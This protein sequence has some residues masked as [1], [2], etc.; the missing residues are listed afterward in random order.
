[1]N[2]LQYKDQQDIFTNA[3]LDQLQQAV[4]NGLYQKDDDV[5]QIVDQAVDKI[6]QEQNWAIER[7]KTFQK[8]N[9][10]GMTGKV[11]KLKK[12][13]SA[14]VDT[15]REKIE[16]Y[17]SNI[18]NI[19][20]SFIGQSKTNGISIYYKVKHKGKEVKARFSDHGV[21]NKD[22]LTDEAHFKLSNFEERTPM[23][24]YKLGHKDYN[25]GPTKTRK[26]IFE[27]PIKNVK[28]S[29]KEISRRK[30]KKGNILVKVERDEK[31]YYDFY[32]KKSDNKTKTGMTG[33]ETVDLSDEINKYTD[34]AKQFAEKINVVAEDV[35]KVNDQ[36]NET[37]QKVTQLSTPKR[38]DSRI[39]KL[40][41][42]SNEPIDFYNVAGETGKFLQLVER[43]S[44]ESV[45][46]TLDGPQGAGKTTTMWKMMN[47]FASGGNEVLFFSLEEH[48]DSYLVEDKK[49]QYIN[50]ANL[51]LINM[52]GDVNDQTDFYS[53][54]KQFDII[55]IDSWQKLIEMVGKIKFDKDMRKHFDGK[56]FVVI[57]QQTVQGK[58][59]GG[60]DISFDGDIIIKLHKDESGDFSKNYAYYDKH[61]YTKKDIN[62][63]KYMIA[64][65]Q[66]VEGPQQQPAQPEAPAGHVADDNIVM[67]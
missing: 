34:K 42:K 61:R 10:K 26:K 57:F 7:A 49:N 3:E 8:S 6:K 53:L 18:D 62:Q 13:G 19:D 31:Y 11:S 9:K 17:L 59:K 51:D 16:K 32:K 33:P 41:D 43:K 55:F 36:V 22:R 38:K 24:M 2:L 60:A 29:D 52:V 46:I 44:K 40:S 50:D 12:E 48:P 4:D 27:V 37:H 54:V 64:A 56:V 28:K 67:L 23:L 1:M 63:L 58:T 25:Y 30:S 20:Y 21:S 35:K 45:A 65:G 66:F 5:K 14:D 15:L 39:K 47:D